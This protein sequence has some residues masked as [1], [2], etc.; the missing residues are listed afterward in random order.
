MT[1]SDSLSLSLKKQDSYVL[2]RK[3]PKKI[4]LSREP[5]RGTGTARTDQIC[6]EDIVAR[7]LQQFATILVANRL[8]TEEVS[9]TCCCDLFSFQ[10]H[11][12]QRINPFLCSFHQVQCLWKVWTAW[13]T[14]QARTFF[15]TL[16]H[17][18][19]WK[20]ISRKQC[21]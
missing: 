10:G 6:K 5:L 18:A 21:G 14:F 4:D 9:E 1:D 12:N 19:W 20:T 13:R 8:R 16:R 7:I 11:C 3:K 17:G 15:R 2:R